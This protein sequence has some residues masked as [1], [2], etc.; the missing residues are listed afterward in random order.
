MR[1]CAVYLAKTKYTVYA[2]MT[3]YISDNLQW[4]NDIYHNILDVNIYWEDRKYYEHTW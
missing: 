3:D 2:A 4:C 1:E